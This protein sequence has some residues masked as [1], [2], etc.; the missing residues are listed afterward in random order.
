[1]RRNL[2]IVCDATYTV[3]PC[4]MDIAVH[5]WI[6]TQMQRH[7]REGQKPSLKQ[8][9]ASV[10]GQWMHSFLHHIIPPYTVY[11]TNLPRATSTV[12]VEVYSCW[13]CSSGE[14]SA[15]ETLMAIFQTEQAMN[16][17]RENFVILKPSSTSVP[18]ATSVAWL[19]PMDFWWKGAVDQCLRCCAQCT[20]AFCDLLNPAKD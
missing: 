19:F 17:I 12:S 3:H 7:Q 14:R 9:D 15:S 10:D 5:Y 6:Q 11:M 16:N 20:R 1:M 4:T 18:T 8:P 2:L 13:C